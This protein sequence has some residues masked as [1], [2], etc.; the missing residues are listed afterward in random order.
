[1]YDTATFTL[2]HPLS[3]GNWRYCCKS[4]TNNHVVAPKLSQVQLLQCKQQSTSVN[5][6]TGVIEVAFYEANGMTNDNVE[7]LRN[8]LRF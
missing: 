1:M 8:H 4:W 5:T 3:P 6:A 2:R 7:H